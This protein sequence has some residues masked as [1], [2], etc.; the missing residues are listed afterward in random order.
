LFLCMAFVLKECLGVI[1]P[2]LN[3]FV[4]SV[5]FWFVPTFM[6]IEKLYYHVHL[7]YGALLRV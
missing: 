5:K 4:A 3:Y 7:E 2:Q 1:F 6:F